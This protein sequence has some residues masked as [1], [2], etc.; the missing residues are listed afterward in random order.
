MAVLGL[1]RAALIGRMAAGNS[2]KA[3]RRLDAFL[4]GDLAPQPVLFERLKAALD[5]D[6]GTFDAA[7]M[8]SRRLEREA[9]ERMIEA[10]DQAWRAAFLPHAVIEKEFSV[11]TQITFAGMVGIKRILHLDLNV[12]QPPVTSRIKPSI[13]WRGIN[14]IKARAALSC[15]LAGFL[16]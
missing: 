15:S 10:E 7:M 11:P 16:G 6:A 8:E 1:D 3:R 14:G 9:W 12:S 4:A 13:G 5:I 2:T